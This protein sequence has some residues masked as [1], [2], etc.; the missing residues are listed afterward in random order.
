[1]F[2]AGT[3]PAAGAA[4]A[5][6]KMQ[7]TTCFC[8]LCCR[9]VQAWSPKVGAFLIFGAWLVQISAPNTNTIITP[10]V[11]LAHTRCAQNSSPLQQP[12]TS[13]PVADRPPSRDRIDEACCGLLL[14]MSPVT[15]AVAMPCARRVYVSLLRQ[16]KESTAAA[17]VHSSDDSFCT[18]Y[19]ATF[20]VSQYTSKHATGGGA[21]CLWVSKGRVCSCTD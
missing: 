7:N 16:S 9:V 4:A 20:L 14:L 19:L 15:T 12:P 18:L 17:A 21:R 10:G 5:P 1:M 3:A 11:S 6:D 2:L 13:P 8:V